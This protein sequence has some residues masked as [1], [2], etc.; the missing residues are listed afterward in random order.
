MKE[1][2]LQS[3]GVY[4]KRFYYDTIVFDPA[5]LRHIINAFGASQIVV[6]SDYP[7][8]VGD[9]DPMGTIIRAG[10]DAATVRAIVAENAERF[11]GRA[12]E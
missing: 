1:A 9:P 10:I 8:N 11:L 3:P 5:A 4:A 6:G 12:L 7:F 2:I